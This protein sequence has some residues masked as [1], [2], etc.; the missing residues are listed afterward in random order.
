MPRHINDHEPVDVNNAVV[1][2]DAHLQ[3]LKAFLT[4]LHDS[5]KAAPQ[6]VLSDNQFMELKA[7]LQPGFELSTLMLDDYKRQRNSPLQR[8]Q[9]GYEVMS[10]ADLQ[11]FNREHGRPLNDQTERNR[12]AAALPAVDYVLE[13]RLPLTA[14]PPEPF[15]ENPPPP[16]ADYYPPPADPAPAE[17]SRPEP[18]MV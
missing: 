11:E 16:P 13:P 5:D 18:D 15:V 9:P 3:E 4:D 8:P 17:R 10:D 14:A 2:T 7:L 12:R 1:I 6:A